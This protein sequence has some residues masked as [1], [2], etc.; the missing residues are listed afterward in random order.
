MRSWLAKKIIRR[1]FA[2]LRAGDYRP[3]L[4]LYTE[5]VRFVFPGDNSWSGEFQG[6]EAAA[7]WLHRLTSIRLQNFADEVIVGGPPWNMS[8]A[9]RG[10]DHV[11]APDG[12]MVYQN[13][14]VLWGRAAWG[15]IKEY[16][17]YEDT[18]KVHALDD[19]LASEGSVAGG[20][21]YG[22]T[23]QPAR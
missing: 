3:L 4:R 18:G 17:V 20:T 21:A 16:E 9:M 6:K 13:R 19:Y 10:H 7:R 23:A 1:V 11:Q 8:I 14:Y 5:D 2:L 12:R 22:D 15:R